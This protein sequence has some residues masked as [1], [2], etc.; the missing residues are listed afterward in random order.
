MDQATLVT[1]AITPIGEEPQWQDGGNGDDVSVLLS[2]QAGA[3]R[4]AA[5]PLEQEAMEVE[6]RECS[7]LLPEEEL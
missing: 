4:P 3:K 1:F 7:V 6:D 2:L 5:A